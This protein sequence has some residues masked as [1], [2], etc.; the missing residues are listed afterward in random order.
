MRRF[1][2]VVV[3]AGMLAV[4]A[5]S[6]ATA[7][8]PGPKIVGGSA[9][10]VQE[11]PWQVALA[12]ND[13]FYPGNGFNRQFCGGTLVAPAIVIT[14]AHCVFNN[15]LPA[16][17]FNPA[18]RF[19]VFTGRT[20]LSSSE[21]QAI[22]V[23]QL[24]YFEGTS[25]APLLQSQ[26]ADP[27]PASGQLYNPSTS[28]WDAVFLQLATP[29]TTG[30]PI[31]IAGADEAALWAAGQ[32]ALI[33][34]WGDQA[35][36]AGDFP[37]QLRA[38]QIQ[39]L[40]DTDCSNAY[41]SGFVTTTMVCAGVLAGGIDTCQGDSGGPLVVQGFQRSSKAANTVRLVG[42]TSFGIGCARPAIPGVYGRVAADPMRSALRNGILQVA[43]VDVVGSGALP[44]DSTGPVV[45][46]TKHP[47]KR[48][49]KNKAKFKFTANEEATFAC[50]LDKGAFKPC[51]SP[52]KKNV[53]DKKHKFRVQATDVQG[54]VGEVDQFKWRVS[55]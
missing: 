48:G 14:A 11:Y 27:A 12:R 41:G 20:N 34:G 18:N 2:A 17:G 23:A 21:G 15:P 50:A 4:G 42:D 19:E 52:F 10:T 54:N 35:E 46:I 29:S 31:K 38:A 37:D 39:M 40:S 7:E 16:I 28:E 36:G 32:P 26:S 43:G 1:G 53:S 51:S 5:A 55:G 33:S 47:K 3:V 8:Q 44:P 45:E 22:D 49:T 9:T 13:A 30:V 24:Y 6:S 25:G